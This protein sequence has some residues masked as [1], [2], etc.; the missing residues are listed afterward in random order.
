[1]ATHAASVWGTTPCTKDNH[2]WQNSQRTFTFDLAFSRQACDDNSDQSIQR[3]VPGHFLHVKQQHMLPR[4]AHCPLFN[5]LQGPPRL[6]QFER[7]LHQVND[8]EVACSHRITLVDQPHRY[9]QQGTTASSSCNKIYAAAPLA[10]LHSELSNFGMTCPKT[11]STDIYALLQANAAAITVLQPG[12]V[13]SFLLLATP[14]TCFG[15][16]E[17]G[18]AVFDV[19]PHQ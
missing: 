13:L 19:G 7:L 6:C 18:L 8:V 3:V 12:Y 4:F 16:V 14:L 9:Q 10:S 2:S 1:M 11:K 17:V 5:N 15:N